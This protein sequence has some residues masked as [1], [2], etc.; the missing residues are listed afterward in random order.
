MRVNNSKRVPMVLAAI[1]VMTWGGGGLAKGVTQIEPPTFRLLSSRFASINPKY[2][3]P[4]LEVTFEDGHKDTVVLE[5]YNA[6]PQS[7]R[8]D[9]TRLCNYLGHLRS[10]EDS[11]VSVTGCF[12]NRNSEGKLYISLLSRRSPFQKSFAMDMRGNVKPIYI[13]ESNNAYITLTGEVFTRNNEIFQHEDKVEETIMEAARDA[14]AN[15][16][17]PYNLSLTVK[18][19]TDTGVSDY[20]VNTLGRTVDE[21]IAEM[22]THVQNHFYHPS[23]NHKV[24]FEISGPTLDFGAHLNSSAEDLHKVNKYSTD[25]ND[26]DV[27]L[28]IWIAGGCPE[29]CYVGFAWLASVCKTGLNTCLVLGPPRRPNAIVAIAETLAHEIGHNLGMKHDFIGHYPELRCRAEGDG[30]ETPCDQCANWSG[31]PNEPLLPQ[32]NRSGECCHGFMDYGP[33]RIAWSD[34]SVRMFRREF[35]T[36]NWARCMLDG[37]TIF[38]II[39]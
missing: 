1:I 19:G 13:A 32:T 30:L 6:M 10:E 27:D 33:Q 28:Y 38:L 8:I 2:Q 18:I 12:D 29:P 14:S 21:W 11:R 31:K 25:A 26:H 17:V 5:H 39:K 37:K 34:C 22:F 9:H 35:V 15:N 24:H 4:E 23:L 3:I 20:I 16:S 7:K 36:Q